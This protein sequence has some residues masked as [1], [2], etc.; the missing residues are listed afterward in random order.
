MQF[1][2]S[3]SHYV[4]DFKKNFCFEN[5]DENYPIEYGNKKGAKIRATAQDLGGD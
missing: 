5:F 2:K 1:T 4:M 3:C